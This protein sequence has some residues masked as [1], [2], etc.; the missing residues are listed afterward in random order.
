[1][2]KGVIAMAW[3]VG[4][5]LGAVARMVRN[6]IAAAR[7]AELDD[8]MLADIGLS[9][10]D[11]RD[12]VSLAPWEDASG[13]LTARVSERRAS[14]RRAP[15]ARLS[16]TEEAYGLPVVSAPSLDPDRDDTLTRIGRL[17]AI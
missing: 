4:R 9:R 1:M 10:T 11:V 14:Q 2:T 16:A 7:L 12:A 17:H 15:V 3:L 6:R 13:L 8:R 5:G